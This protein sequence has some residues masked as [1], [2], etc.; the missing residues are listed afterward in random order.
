[1]LF[2]LSNTV[3][4]K[5][6]K[7]ILTSQK[8]ATTFITHSG[9]KYLNDIKNV[10]D[11]FIVSPSLANN[12]VF[13]I[14][15]TLLKSMPDNTYL[16]SGD[17]TNYIP[18]VSKSEL[19]DDTVKKDETELEKISVSDGLTSQ[20][21]EDGNI[22]ANIEEK[23][24]E[25]IN[26]ISEDI[27]V[28]ERIDM[29]GADTEDEEPDEQSTQDEQEVQLQEEDLEDVNEEEPTEEEVVRLNNS[30]ETEVHHNIEIQDYVP[31]EPIEET[32]Q[33]ISLEESLEEPIEEN[34]TE[35]ETPKMV[36]EEPELIEESEDTAI[37][38]GDDIDLDLEEQ[39]ENAEMVEEL[40]EANNEIEE[41]NNE[42]EVLPVSED[43]EDYELD[44]IVELNPED[45]SD[46]D[47]VIDM[48]ENLSEE[49]LDEQIVK[50]V[51]KVFTTRID[52]DIS[53]SDL[54]FI[55]E[56]NNDDDELLEEVT[57][58][59]DILE[60]TE[61]DVI[62]EEPQD[63]LKLEDEDDKI[64]ETRNASTPIVPVYEANIPQEDLVM[65]DSIQQ[66]DSVTHAKYGNGV[67]EKMIKY[68]NKTLF[69]I[70]F[71]NIGR[72]LL[73]PTLTEI[74]KA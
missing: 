72:R 47:I 16:I 56:L 45:A 57:D 14:Y 17:T 23:S 12:R 27:N 29:F 15:S 48:D 10:F 61:D 65:S 53:D 73:D 25:T 46:N 60:P 51:D 18:I 71:D 3:S 35:E 4:K 64:L 74:K 31:E 52:D 59:S 69:S 41:V 30:F 55:D 6:I 26:K 1:M 19:I 38:L 66:G 34:T 7:D 33:E 58:N 68:G 9:F 28:P 70:N 54:D 63:E 13:D 11:N 8:V 2:E 21:I 5:N 67:V 43:T 44:N 20:T 22:L 62:L 32:P 39:E 50:D 42:L 49:D 36:V 40:P 37:E 24:E